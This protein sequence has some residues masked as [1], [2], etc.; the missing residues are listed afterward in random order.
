MMR[1]TEAGHHLA[2]RVHR[3]LIETVSALR[4][5]NAVVGPVA[6]DHRAPDVLRRAFGRVV[7]KLP[8]RILEVARSEEPIERWGRLAGRGVEL[9]GDVGGLAA[10][11]RVFAHAAPGRA[12]LVT[13]F[14]YDELKEE[15]EPGFRSVAASFQ[16]RG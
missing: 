13:E 16:F 8:R 12:L 14:Y 4:V 3:R 11:L 6:D 1:M 5:H 10:T 2:L 7:A 9:K 15:L